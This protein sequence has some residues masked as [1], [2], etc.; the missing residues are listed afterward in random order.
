MAYRLHD[1]LV[2]EGDDVDLLVEHIGI[3]KGKLPGSPAD[4]VP[5]LVVEDADAG[6]RTQDLGHF[7]LGRRAGMDLGDLVLRRKVAP[8][9]HIGRAA[10]DYGCA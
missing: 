6:W 7:V 2:V 1:P 10:G 3:E 9:F 5:C 4:V 8:L